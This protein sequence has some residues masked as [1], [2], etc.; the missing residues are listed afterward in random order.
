MENL[1][2]LRAELIREA[3]ALLAHPLLLWGRHRQLTVAIRSYLVVMPQEELAKLAG[4]V[5]RYREIGSAGEL[6]ADTGPGD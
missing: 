1:E 3:E 6:D 5:M 2:S 4:L